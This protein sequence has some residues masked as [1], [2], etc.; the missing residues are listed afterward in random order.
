VWSEK[1]TVRGV[2]APVLDRYAVGFRVMHGF[3]SATAVYEVAQSSDDKDLV[4]LYVG[5]FDPSGLFMSEQDLPTRLFEY[6]AGED[7]TVERIALT[8]NQVIGLPSFPVTDKR[9]DPRFR[10]FVANH[11][12]RC[13]ELDAMDPNDLR[14]CVESAIV[15]LIEP[16]AWQRCETINKAEQESLRTVIAR[17]RAADDD[18]EVAS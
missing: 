15:D 18:P 11:G 9:K 1:G 13:W 12:D 5:D 10:W 3:S 14:D 2:L 7:V 6:G 17:W 8:Q 4:A 16:E